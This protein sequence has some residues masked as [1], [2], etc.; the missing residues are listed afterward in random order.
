MYCPVTRFGHTLTAFNDSYLILFGGVSEYKEKL[1]DRCF[2]SDVWTYN[3]IKNTWK[4]IEFA[5]GMIKNRKNHSACIYKGYYLV[6]GGV[7]ESEEIINEL[8]WVNF[9]NAMS[10]EKEKDKEKLNNFGN[11]P[12]AI[13][14]SMCSPTALNTKNRWRSKKLEARYNH[15]M[16]VF[17]SQS[18]DYL[19]VCGGRN[20]QSD[21][22]GDLA[23]YQI[24]IVEGE[25]IVRD[26]K[27][28]T[29]GY[30]LNEKIEIMPRE[31]PIMACLSSGIV[32]LGGS[33]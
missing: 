3:V 28:I 7:D 13:L 5:G 11:N 22:I 29:H 10:E 2:Y 19:A 23:L 18:R 27:R 33:S 21:I 31:M 16:L 8:S 17:Q 26:H 1:K 20:A 24:G 15:Q 4:I 12:F 32:I 9:A 30:H 6:Y 25:L 14:S